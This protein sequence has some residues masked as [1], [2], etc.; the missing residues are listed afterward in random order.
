MIPDPF[1]KCDEKDLNERV[2]ELPNEELVTESK[3]EEEIPK[4]P[5]E[6]LFEEMTAFHQDDVAEAVIKW[7]ESP[8]CGNRAFRK[9]V[10]YR[11]T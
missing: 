8:H 11:S 1:K 6:L 4:S 10:D 5:I 7:M 2:E 3:G 9:I